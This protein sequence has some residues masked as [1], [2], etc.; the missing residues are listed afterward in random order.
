MV[1]DLIGQG[2]ESE[3]VNYRHE[4]VCEIEIGYK[5]ARIEIRKL[6]R[7]DYPETLAGWW[8]DTA[9]GSLKLAEPVHY[10]ELPGAQIWPQVQYPVSNNVVATCLHP[11]RTGFCRLRRGPTC[12]IQPASPLYI[13]CPNQFQRAAGRLL[14]DADRPDFAA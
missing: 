14:C 12:T 8:M 4:N 9:E 6:L 13:D 10:S 1:S 7:D 2:A 5:P 3:D 11:A